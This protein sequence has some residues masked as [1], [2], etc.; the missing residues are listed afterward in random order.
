VDLAELVAGKV[1]F[2]HSDMDHS[3]FDILSYFKQQLL[4]L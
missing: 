4:F 2:N 3:A 1:G